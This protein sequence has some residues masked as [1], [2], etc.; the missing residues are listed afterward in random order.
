M[1]CPNCLSLY[2]DRGEIVEPVAPEWMES[3]PILRSFWSGELVEAVNRYAEVDEVM[4]GRELYNFEY[5]ARDNNGLRKKFRIRFECCC[6]N[7]G[8]VWDHYVGDTDVETYKMT[9]DQRFWLSIVLTAIIAFATILCSAIWGYHWKQVRMAEAGY[10]KLEIPV[11]STTTSETVWR[12]APS[13]N[14]PAEKK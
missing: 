5:V 4:A 14:Q 10:E 1:I 3:E 9:P 12:K 2:R 8:F 13:S 7:C 6:R 11:T